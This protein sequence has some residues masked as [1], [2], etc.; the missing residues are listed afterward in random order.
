MAQ[1][2]ATW[3]LTIEDPLRWSSEPTPPTTGQE[4]VP[5]SYQFPAPLGGTGVYSWSLNGAPAGMTL[6]QTGLLEWPN[7]VAGWSGSLTVTV[8]DA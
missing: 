7:P 6:S 1:I 8:S 2:A 4:G 5:I 3:T